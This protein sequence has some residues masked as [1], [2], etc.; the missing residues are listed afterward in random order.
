MAYVNRFITDM[1]DQTSATLKSPRR[2]SRFWRR[3]REARAARRALGRAGEPPRLRLLQASADEVP[4]D[5]PPDEGLWARAMELFTQNRGLLESRIAVATKVLPV[6]NTSLA[7]ATP[8]GY[9]RNDAFG[10]GRIELFGA[11][12]GNA[13]PPDAPVSFPHTWGM[14]YTGW[15]QWGANTNSVMERNIGQALGVGAVVDPGDWSSSVNVVNLNRMEHLT[16][17]LKAPAWPAAFPAV[18]AAKAERGRQRFTEYCAGCHEEWTSRGAMRD[19]KLFALSRVGTDPNTALNY[20]KNVMA[21]VTRPETDGNCAPVVGTDGQPIVATRTGPVPFPA[22]ALGIIVNVKARAYRDLGLTDEQTRQLENQDERGAPTFR[23]PLLDHQ[24]WD[25]TRGRKVYRAKTLV[26]IWATAPYLHN[27][28][29]PTIY[30]LLQPAARRPVA[31]T[32]GQHEQDPVKLGIQTD[33]SKIRRPPGWKPFTLD[34]R[35]HGNWN[36]GHEW[37]FYPQLDDEQRYEII[38]FLK[39][40]DD[41]SKLQGPPAN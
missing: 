8:D 12:A 41:D 13:V 16:Y 25:D 28:S 30:D 20:E 37:E 6:L 33:E 40:F 5:P 34:T 26:G 21:T 22:A 14:A 35:L 2:L 27:G 19:Y 23:A 9:G 17:K 3:V 10:V 18:D 4:E 31:F 29:V 32:T 24:C 39:V 11:T 15:L 38:E 1:F 36:T 7:I